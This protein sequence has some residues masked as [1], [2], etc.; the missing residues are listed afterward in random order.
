MKAVVIGPGRIGCGFAGHLLSQ[1]GYELVFVGRGAIVGALEAQRRY[2]VR[3]VNGSRVARHAVQGVRALHLDD[4][5]AVQEI[6]EA[7]LVAVSVGP[8]NL[9]S[10]APLLAMA[11]ARRST[12]VNVLAF[13]NAPEAGPQLRREV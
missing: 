8:S 6:A 13:E 5:R 11:L 10:V 9:A 2:D 4:P 7:D 3:L 1:S 12:P